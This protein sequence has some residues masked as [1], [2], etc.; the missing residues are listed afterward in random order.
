M[1]YTSFRNYD[2]YREMFYR[3]DG[4]RKNKILLDFLTCNDLHTFYKTDKSYKRRFL[5]QTMVGLYDYCMEKISQS[6]PHDSL[7]RWGYI[8]LLGYEFSN[9][10]YYCDGQKGVCLNGDIQ[11]Y[12]YKRLDNHKVYEM[13]VGKLFAQIIED[14]RW[15]SKLPKSVKIYLCEEVTKRWKAERL[16]E[17]SKYEL[18]YGSSL[19][20]FRR[21]YDYYSD[22]ACGFHSCMSGGSHADF[23]TDAVDATAA[24]I[25]D[26]ET[27]DIVARCVIYDKV[28]TSYGNII[29]LAERQYAEDEKDYLKAILI[30]KLIKEGLIDGY[31]AI[32]ADCH[33]AGNFLDINGK[34]FEN[35]DFS[36]EC[37][38]DYGD[39]L[40]YQDSFKWYNIIKGR[41]YNY[42]EDDADISLSETDA[43]LY[44]PR[45]YDDYH[46][47]YT[48]ND[49]VS[50]YCYGRWISCDDQE[51]DDFILIRG[52]YYHED[53]VSRCPECGD[54][55]LTDD[56]YEHEES[57]DV[58]CCLQ[59]LE[60]YYPDYNK[61]EE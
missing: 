13:K 48:E 41:A 40:S 39:T 7:T 28:M 49:V 1:L 27:G 55:F 2:E 45:N 57:G 56:G 4:S 21:I 43:T 5:K 10:L 20:D 24:W 12:R 58:F 25:R 31:K 50:V 35:T 59:C 30:N 42:P 9:T 44:D 3:A 6:M 26:V 8:E 14:N 18:D 15:G 61:D 47:C 33:D 38:L 37:R 17:E 51:L 11:S 54:Y 29:R 16:E 34:K 53:Y 46:E 36:I 23:Y 19:T 60:D 52:D 32:G 22:C